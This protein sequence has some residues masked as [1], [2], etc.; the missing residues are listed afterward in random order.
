MSRAT[1]PDEIDLSSEAPSSHELTEVATEA[2]LMGQ[3][4]RILVQTNG[5][6]VVRCRAQRAGGT[7]SRKASVLPR[8]S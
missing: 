2:Q 6:H 7:E 3:N 1:A 4:G 5:R 8:G